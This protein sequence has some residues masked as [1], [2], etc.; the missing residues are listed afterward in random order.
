MEEIIK[1]I[2]QID[3]DAIEKQERNKKE[4]EEKENQKK[5]LLKKLKE[6]ISSNMKA[7]IENA[8]KMAEDEI[9]TESEKIKTEAAKKLELL[10]GH[11]S[12]I[13]ASL[14]DDAF[15]IVIRSLEG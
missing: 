8:K 7:E 9:D 2:L 14:S 13:A 4:L 11:Y 3:K 1:D 15:E 10:E 5:L 6:D 12:D